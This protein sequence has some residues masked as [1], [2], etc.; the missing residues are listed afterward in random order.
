MITIKQ[1]GGFKK[2]DSFCEKLKRIAKVS[3][4]DIYGQKGVEALRAAT[5]KDSGITADSWIYTIKRTN[6]T[7][8]LEWKNTNVNDGCNIAVLIQY[9]HATKNGGY[10]R[11]TDYINPAIK[12]VFD[13]ISRDIWEEVKKA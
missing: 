4:L 12:P 7:I 6:D 8:E 11:G 13:E 3:N 1:N 10:V 2:F 9:G 5:P